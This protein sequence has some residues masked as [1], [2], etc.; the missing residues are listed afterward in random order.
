MASKAD[1][2]T[3][4]CPFMDKRIKLLPCQKEMIKWYQENE[5]MSQRKLAKKFGVYRR[6]IQFILD[7]K[8]KEENLK[9]REE[10]GGTMAYYDV[11]KHRDY[12]RTHRANKTEI[13]NLK[14]K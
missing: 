1:K 9:R 14:E 4:G 8:K 5:G 2:I 13:I 7:P 12:M 11:D 3:V 6:T 10:R